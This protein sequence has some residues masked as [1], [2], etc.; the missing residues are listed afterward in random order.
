[1]FGVLQESCVLPQDPGKLLVPVKLRLDADIVAGQPLP[2]VDTAGVQGQGEALV[3]VVLFQLAQV[4]LKLR[5][6]FPDGRK[7]DLDV[8][9]L[10]PGMILNSRNNNKRC[11]GHLIGRKIKG[12]NVKVG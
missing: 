10:T 6:G 7:K 3:L 8:K 12:C 5:Q 11:W 2:G 1:M 4:V 9:L